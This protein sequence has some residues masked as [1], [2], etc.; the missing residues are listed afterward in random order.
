MNDTS[1]YDKALSGSE[2]NRLVFEINDEVPVKDEEELIVVVMLVPMVF[3]LHHA[4]A[5]DGFIDFAQCLVVPLI[6]ASLHE[7]RDINDR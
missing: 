6:G 3:T 5:D 2:I 1:W 4:Q 7:S